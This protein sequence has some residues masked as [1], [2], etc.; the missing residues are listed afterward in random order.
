MKKLILCLLGCA[1]ACFATA[2]YYIDAGSMSFGAGRGSLASQVTVTLSGAPATQQRIFNYFDMF[3]GELQISLPPGVT[4]TC[5]GG[6]CNIFTT[7]ATTS[8]VYNT[9]PG[10]APATANAPTSY[11]VDVV[12]ASTA[13]GCSSATAGILGNTVP[14]NWPVSGSVNLEIGNKISADAAGYICA[15]RFLKPSA[16]IATSHTVHLWNG[17]ASIATATSAGEAASGWI[18]VPITPTA[19]AAGAVY[20]ASYSV[21]NTGLYYIQGLAENASPHNGPIRIVGHYGGSDGSCA[22][23]DHWPTNPDGLPAAGTVGC[24]DIKANG[25]LFSA[26]RTGNS[27]GGSADSRWNTTE[28]S[29][30][31]IGGV[32]PGPY[33]VI[34]TRIDGSGNKW[35]H[36]DSGAWWSAR[37]DYYY[38]R[39]LFTSPLYTMLGT[40]YSDGNRYYTRQSQEWKSGRRIYIGGSIYE[41][42]LNDVAP[43]SLLIA[44]SNNGYGETD[45]NME[46]NEFRH[47]PGGFWWSGVYYSGFYAAPPALRGRFANNIFWDL[48]SYGAPG[49]TPGNAWIWQ[50]GSAAEDTVLDHNTVLPQHGRAPALIYLYP[51]GNE[52][53]TITNNILPVDSTRQLFSGEHNCPNR[54]GETV[55]T[56]LFNNYTFK[57]NLLYPSQYSYYHP[58]TGDTWVSNETSAD[59]ASQFPINGGNNYI[60]PSTNLSAMKWFKLPS[61]PPDSTTVATAGDFHLRYDSPASVGHSYPAIDGKNLGVD[62]QAFAIAQGYVDHIGVPASTLTATSATVVFV[63]PDSQACPVDFKVYD[64]TDPNTINGFTRV[65]DT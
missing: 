64:P 10:S 58:P 51:T 48:A 18:T 49:Q 3:S 40:I 53:M 56:C 32:G 54:D 43:S 44:L 17:A 11:A 39:N 50:G 30:A 47:G 4:G 7:D 19:I 16:D 26:F 52:A 15:V 37:G 57:N 24:A 14:F 36:D 31:M 46:Y 23:S 2:T 22:I 27:G 34:N 8:S 1:S 29:Q 63:A 60:Y 28:G 21:I 12:Y 5:R 61:F 65:P 13:A 38:Y 9:T 55:M 20:I 42:S 35:H 25:T 33:A 62:M 59:I 6:T 45:I 41:N